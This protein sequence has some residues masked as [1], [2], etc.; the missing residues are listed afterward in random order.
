LSLSGK[1]RE[2]VQTIKRNPNRTQTQTRPNQVPTQYQP[3]AAPPPSHLQVVLVSV[4]LP[5]RRLDAAGPIQGA[6]LPGEVGAE[7]DR[8][9][10]VADV[11]QVG[12]D[13]AR[14]QLFGVG[15]WVGGRAGGL[16]SMW[17]E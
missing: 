1:K 12:E 13:V 17:V 9:D 2:P 7:A 14:Q 8:V 6:H 10:G 16:F 4:Q 3:S 5:A 15:G 11:V